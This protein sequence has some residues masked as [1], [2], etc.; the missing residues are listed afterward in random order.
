VAGNGYASQIWKGDAP[1][2]IMGLFVLPM[3]QVCLQRRL[4]LRRLFCGQTLPKS[5]V[6]EMPLFLLE[7]KG[8]E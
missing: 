3:K 6:S 7:H 5:G 2:G 1:E 4:F 8:E